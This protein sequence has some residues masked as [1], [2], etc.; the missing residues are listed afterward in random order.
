M[1]KALYI[2]HLVSQMNIWSASDYAIKVGAGGC[3][4]VKVTTNSLQCMPP[5]EKPPA[6]N[7]DRGGGTLPVLV[8][9]SS[10]EP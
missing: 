6:G 4:E 5:E 3:D 7:A 2:S 10:V 9:R 1:Y 8:S